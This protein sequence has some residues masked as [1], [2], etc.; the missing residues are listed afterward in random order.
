[1]ALK[2][3]K[4]YEGL[5]LSPYKDSLGYL[6]IGYGHLCLP[7]DNIKV[8]EEITLQEAEEFYQKD[9]G[10][11]M[12]GVKELMPSWASLEPIAYNILINLCYNMGE[13]DLSKFHRTLRAFAEHRYSDAGDD[14]EDSIWYGQVGQRAIDIVEALHELGNK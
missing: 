13:H 10:I 9:V 5:R 12:A 14:L 11:A 2:T 1:M 8:G 6:T 3:I 4:E 7:E